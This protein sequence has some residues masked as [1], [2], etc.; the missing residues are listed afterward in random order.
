VTDGAA[1]GAPL[2]GGYYWVQR[3]KKQSFVFTPGL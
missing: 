1:T 2:A 3:G